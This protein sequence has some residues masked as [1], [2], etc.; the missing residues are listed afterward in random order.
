MNRLFYLIFIISASGS[1]R[2]GICAMIRCI[3]E[4]KIIYTVDDF[5]DV[6]RLIDITR[7]HTPIIVI[8]SRSV[9]GEIDTALEM[10]KIKAPQ[11]RC[12]LLVEQ[13]KDR[14]VFQ[15]RGADAVLLEGFSGAQFMAA[16]R[17]YLN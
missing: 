15:N 6:L 11:S 5:R 1:R 12:I 14:E 2:Q 7:N 16:S 3:P 4:A 10:L 9:N 17:G 8:D 13:P